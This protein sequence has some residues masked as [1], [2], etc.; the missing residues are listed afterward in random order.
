MTNQTLLQLSIPDNLRGLVISVVNLNA[1]PPP[2]GGLIAGVG[3]DLLGGPKTITLLLAGISAGLAICFLF[4]SKTT[5]NYRLSEATVQDEFPPNRFSRAIQSQ[6][7]TGP[8]LTCPCENSCEKEFPKSA[9]TGKNR[10][11]RGKKE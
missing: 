10:K 3:S 11:K 4:S 5:R 9:K 1:A 8:I 2:F 6:P 7:H